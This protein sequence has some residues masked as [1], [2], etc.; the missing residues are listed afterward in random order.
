MLSA[1]FCRSEDGA[2]VEG[3]GRPRNGSRDPAAWDFVQDPAD[4]SSQISSSAIIRLIMAYYADKGQ[5]LVVCLDFLHAFWIRR[6]HDS[7]ERSNCGSPK[8]SDLP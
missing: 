8:R 1:K 5:N 6:R 7:H 2:R 4:S 3:P